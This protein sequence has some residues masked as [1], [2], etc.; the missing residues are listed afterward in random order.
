MKNFS[1]S[2]VSDVFFIAA[3]SFFVSL[4]FFNYFTP[5]PVNLVAAGV[6]SGLCA[7]FGAKLLSIRRERKNFSAKEA[8]E[9]ADFLIR[10]NVSAQKNVLNLA[11]AVAEKR[12]ESCERKNGGLYFKNI[13]LFVFFKFGFD[14]V[15]KA[16]V[17]KAFNKLAKSDRA[18]LVSSEPTVEMQ[19]FAARFDGKIEL[20]DARKFFSALKDADLLPKGGFTLL[21]EKEKKGS[22]SLLFDRKK[23]KNYL[24]FGSIFV[25]F[26]FFVPIKIYYFATGGIMLIFAL[27]VRFAGKKTG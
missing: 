23:A 2:A 11:K 21:P 14:A 19:N 22:F 12:G 10:I 5:F 1:L 13:R 8:A 24:V 20:T 26:G 16:D 3:A 9:Y 18:I 4:I 15:T 27:L 7:I 17:V 6:F 25:I